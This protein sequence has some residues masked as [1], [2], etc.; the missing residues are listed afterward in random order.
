M[1]Q[2]Y[3][4][5]KRSII[6]AFAVLISLYGC[7]DSKK[8]Y[9]ENIGPVVMGLEQLGSEMDT[10]VNALRS[11]GI[12]IVEFETKIQ[13]IENRLRKEKENFVHYVAP[14]EMDLFQKNIRE[15]IAG[16]EL[17]ISAIKSY[18]TRKNMLKLAERQIVELEKEEQQMMS[19]DK[20]DE[21]IKNRLNKISIERANLQKQKENLTTEMDAQL[22]FY[23][24]SHEYFIKMVKAMKTSLKGRSR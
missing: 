16:E 17:A 2:E 5:M 20:K 24:N 4:V 23:S 13:D 21:K 6:F 3:L 10:T 19:K 14:M 12:S 1:D 8:E 9:T 18:A 15:A 11:D 22:K 7:K